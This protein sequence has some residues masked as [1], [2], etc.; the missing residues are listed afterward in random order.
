MLGQM[1]GHFRLKRVVPL[2]RSAG[3]ESCDLEHGSQSFQVLRRL[4]V[5]DLIPVLV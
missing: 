3:G 4:L 5:T 1:R 2:D